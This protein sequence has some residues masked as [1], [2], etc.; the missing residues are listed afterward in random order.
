MKLYCAALRVCP[1]IKDLLEGMLTST[2]SVAVRVRPADIET[3]HDAAAER[4]PGPDRDGT[5]TAIMDR[6]HHLDVPCSG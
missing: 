6:A 5:C 4:V 2:F 3:N 1:Q